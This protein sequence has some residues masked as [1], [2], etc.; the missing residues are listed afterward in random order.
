MHTRGAL[1][2]PDAEGSAEVLS[3]LLHGVI[4]NEHYSVPLGQ[5][6]VNVFIYPSKNNNGY[7]SAWLTDGGAGLPGSRYGRF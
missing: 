5:E 1:I 6:Q 3:N 2:L 7:R 4:S